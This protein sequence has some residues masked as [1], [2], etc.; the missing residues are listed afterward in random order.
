MV[1]DRRGEC[2]QD[3]VHL[4]T[5]DAQTPSHMLRC[6]RALLFCDKEALLG[7]GIDPKDV[8]EAADLSL[9]DTLACIEYLRARGRI[10][11]HPLDPTEGFLLE[12]REWFETLYLPQLVRTSAPLE[13]HVGNKYEQ[14][15]TNSSVGAA[16][17][18]DHSRASHTQG[19]WSQDEWRKSIEAAQRA[20][21]SEQGKLDELAEG[22]YEG[23]SQLLRVARKINIEQTEQAQVLAQIEDAID[24]LWADGSIKKLGAGGDAL[25]SLETLKALTGPAATL[26]SA[27]LEA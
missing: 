8:A 10:T 3:V 13:I 23:L 20:L 27:L 5:D 22:L 21:V 26:V 17:V 7:D 18:G 1:L 25:R 16:A 6:V 24:D 19:V 9:E 12:S 14:N 15:I 11:P 2:D 4:M